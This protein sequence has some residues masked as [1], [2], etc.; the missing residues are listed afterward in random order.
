MATYWLDLVRYAD[1]VGYHGDQD[2]ATSRRT[3]TTSSTRSTR[4]CR[5]TGSPSSSSPATCCPNPT[6]EQQIATGYNRLLQTTHE[7]GVQAEGV[8]GEVRGRPRA[9]R[10]RRCGWARRSAAPSATTT[11]STRTRQKDFYALAAFFADVDEEKHLRGGGADAVPT[12][13]PPEMPVHTRRERERLAELDAQIAELEAQARRAD[14]RQKQLAGADEGARRA[15]EGAAARDGHAGAVDAADDARAAARQL[16]GRHR[17]RWSSRPCPRSCGKLDGEGRA[18]RGS[19][20]RTGSTD[21]KAGA[22]GLT[23]RVFVNRLWKLFFGAGLSQVA[24]RLRRRR[25]SRRRTR[26]CS[27]GWPSSSSRAAGT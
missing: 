10:R 13:R 26:S 14:E 23:A 27:T 22:G 17:R 15:R 19:T 12:K 11:S 3:A 8:P 9:E 25:A 6:T 18:R 20:W 16:A 21:A 7:G 24:R 4:T 2:H 1:T 5:S